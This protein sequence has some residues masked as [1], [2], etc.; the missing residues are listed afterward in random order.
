MFLFLSL[1]LT[2]SLSLSVITSRDRQELLLKLLR[3]YKQMQ[4]HWESSVAGGKCF[5]CIQT[6]ITGLLRTLQCGGWTGL[7][8]LLYGHIRSIGKRFLILA[9]SRQQVCDQDQD[10]SLVKAK[11]KDVNTV[12]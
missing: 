8:H 6:E 7:M 9:V 3:L 4:I 12:D 5:S 11:Q 1:S 10:V 2:F